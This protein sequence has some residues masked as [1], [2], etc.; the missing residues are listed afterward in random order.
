[1][2]ACALWAL[3]TAAP[4]LVRGGEIRGLRVGGGAGYD[5]LVF[6]LGTRPVAAYQVDGAELLIELE[7]AAPVLDPATQRRL[8]KLGVKLVPTE[9][10]TRVA[11]ERRGRPA[12]AFRL[13]G[14]NPGG[15]ARV[16]LDLGK[17]SAPLAIPADAEA[18][19]VGAPSA[20]APV[21]EIPDT[22]LGDVETAPP[23]QVWVR[24]RSIDFAGIPEGSPTREELL[25]V[26]L[27]VAL[28]ENGDLSAAPEG[29]PAQRLTLR[30]L[31]G[32]ERA[33]GRVSGSVLQ[34]I[35]QRI[36]DQYAAQGRYGTRID[37][38]KSDLEELAADDRGELRIRIRGADA[39]AP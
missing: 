37:I 26:E 11:V 20:P 13:G 30:E 33:D 16:V 7:A 3:L 22:G 34:Q 28:G 38:Q 39:E 4:D 8:S 29:A 32:G 1:V 17:G 15:A 12:V 27:Q 9:R 2:L 24:V 36:A 18:L 35:V 5:R 14:Q 6:D 25:D 21:S 31:I 23:E 10:G 19:P